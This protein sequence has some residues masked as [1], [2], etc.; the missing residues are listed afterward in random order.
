MWGAGGMLRVLSGFGG[1]G[2]G[3]DGYGGRINCRGR[4]RGLLGGWRGE[5]QD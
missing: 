5:R 2:G 3:C 1:D 4:I